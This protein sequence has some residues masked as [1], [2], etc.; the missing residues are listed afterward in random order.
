MTFEEIKKRLR[1]HSIGIAGAGGLGSNC[2]VSLVRA[3]IGSLVIADFDVV[4]ESN[5]NRQFFFRDQIGMKKVKALADNLYRINPYL[6]LTLV[7]KKITPHNFSD[8]FSHCHALVEAFDLADQ[9]QMLIETLMDK[10]PQKPLIVGSGMAGWGNNNTIKTE[11]F[12]NIYVCGDGVSEIA[13]E[14]P[15]IGPRVAIVANMQ[16]NQVLEILLGE[17]II[18]NKS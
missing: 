9:K 4:N 10:F 8:Y 15:P 11:K 18:H 12:D 13:H 17:Q 16:A 5:L 14:N 7:A 1:K 2:A 3:G 6:D